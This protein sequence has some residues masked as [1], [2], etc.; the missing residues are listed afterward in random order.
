MSIMQ[1]RAT[2]TTAGA[3]WSDGNRRATGD[4]IASAI[5]ML[6]LAAGFLAVYVLPAVTPDDPAAA[7]PVAAATATRA[8]TEPYVNERY[9]AF[10]IS[11]PFYYRSDV[12]FVRPDDTD[13][14]FKRMGWDG[15]ALMPPIDGGV[16]VVKWR[17]NLGFMIDFLH[18]KAVSRLGKGAHGRK[19]DN[20]VI[21]TVKAEGRIA[22]RPAPAEIKLTDFFERF[23]FTHGHNVLMAT[24]LIRMADI[25]PGIRPYAGIGA[26]V[27]IPHVEVWYPGQDKATRT[28]EYQYAG[29]AWQVVA[30][31]EYRRGNTSFFLEYKFNYAWIAGSLT[32]DQ[33][34]MNFN[35]PGDLWRQFKRWWAG[36]KPKDG[37]FSTTLGAHQI[38][39]G[40]GYWIKG[41]QPAAP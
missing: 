10:Y 20:P 31:L 29:P 2:R 5:A 34:W 35:M 22:G 23:E 38:A 18:N 19:I 7:K 41:R 9:F 8:T 37:H 15:D 6:A 26:G 16:R 32:G 3:A 27:A 1:M 21:E 4:T 14:V 13:V 39:V 25:F 24:P 28:N 40:G 33:S 17:H 30:G 36:E 11:Q 12:H